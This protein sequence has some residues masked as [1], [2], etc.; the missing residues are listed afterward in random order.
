M[1]GHAAI[2]QHFCN[3]VLSKTENCRMDSITIHY[4]AMM[5]S[6]LQSA[7]LKKIKNHPEQYRLL[8]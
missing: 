5:L 7:V 6:T 8:M 1:N 3:V 2:K 4:A